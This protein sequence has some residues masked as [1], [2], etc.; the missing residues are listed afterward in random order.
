[1]W[2][3]RTVTEAGARGRGLSVS[4]RNASQFEAGIA[5]F[6]GSGSQGGWCSGFESCGAGGSP[7]AAYMK[8]RVILQSL[9][10]R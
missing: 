8:G 10:M 3:A 5:G 4:T 7:G 1:M 6:D 9:Q 2:R